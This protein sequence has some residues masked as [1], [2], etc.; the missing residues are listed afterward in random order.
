MIGGQGLVGGGFA[1]SGGRV[2]MREPNL[3]PTAGKVI[4][5]GRLLGGFHEQ[6]QQLAAQ[7]GHLVVQ[8]AEGV[9]KIALRA[10]ADAMQRK[11]ALLE[12]LDHA[13]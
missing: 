4:G 6:F 11:N 12:P 7:G 9:R 1:D 5:G 13:P 3:P 8:G 2:A 10:L